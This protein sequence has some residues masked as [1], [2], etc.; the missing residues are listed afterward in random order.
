[1]AEVNSIKRGHNFKDLAGMVVGRL[2]VI[3]VS[4]MKP[5]TK[6]L[7]KCECGSECEVIAGKLLDKIR[8]TNSCGC[9]AKEVSAETG[10]KHFTHRM[11]HGPEYYS[12]QGMKR[13][14]EDPKTIGFEKYGGRGITV[15]ERWRNSFEAFFADMGPRPTRSHSIDRFPDNN[16]NYEPG[17]C[18][19]ATKKEQSRNTRTNRVLVYHGKQMSV[20]ELCEL[21][22]KS[23]STIANRLDRGWSVEDAIDKP[24][25]SSKRSHKNGRV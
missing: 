3:R 9:L 4:G 11:S 8:P 21:S 25:D 5:R 24:V 15:C 1:M 12:W 19:W 17:N 16:G 2:T 7:C 6:W 18:R 23:R 20:A 13:R 22:G 10:R 14:C